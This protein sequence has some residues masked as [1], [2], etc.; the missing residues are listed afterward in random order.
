MSLATT[1]PEFFTNTISTFIADSNMG[2]GTIIG[3]MLFNTLGV[4][5]VAGLATSSVCFKCFV[6]ELNRTLTIVLFFQHVQLHH[7]PILRDC[8]IFSF[9]L[10]VLAAITWDGVIVWYESTIQVCLLAIYFAIMFQSVPLQNYIHRLT[11]GKHS[12]GKWNF[13]LFIR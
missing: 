10:I 9:N 3:S 7:W 1:T 4:S 13:F 8:V 2:L 6:K 5:A 11:K 12:Y